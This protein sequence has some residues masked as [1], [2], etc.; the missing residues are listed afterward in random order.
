[1][2]QQALTVALRPHL[3]GEFK[4]EY[5]NANECSTCEDVWGPGLT[6]AGEA[7]TSESDCNREHCRS[8]CCRATA[9]CQ[10]QLNSRACN[11]AYTR[12]TMQSLSLATRSSM[13]TT[14]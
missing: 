6:T 7:S 10:Q 1:M 14:R 2:W 8:S 3:Q 13:T 12:A 4:E 9:S 11:Q 5:G